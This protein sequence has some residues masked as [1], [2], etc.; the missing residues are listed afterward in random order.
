[1]SFPCHRGGYLRNALASGMYVG[2]QERERNLAESLDEYIRRDGKSSLTTFSSVIDA[3]DAAAGVVDAAA[4]AAP[5]AIAAPLIEAFGN[6]SEFPR[7][8][9]RAPCGMHT[10]LCFLP[11]ASITDELSLQSAAPC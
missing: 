9:A 3:A 10:L 1:M 7:I 6:P 4:A 2:G 5:D 11:F 8:H